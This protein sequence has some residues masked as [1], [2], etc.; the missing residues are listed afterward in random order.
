VGFFQDRKLPVTLICTRPLSVS[1]PENGEGM[2]WPLPF[3]SP[4]KLGQV[5]L[6]GAVQLALE[7]F[8][9]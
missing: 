1:S 6:P 9:P 5:A 7:G 8:S 4:R 2:N 3:L